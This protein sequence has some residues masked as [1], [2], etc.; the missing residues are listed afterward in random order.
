MAGLAA[1]VELA[2]NGEKVRILEQHHELGG[3][4]VTTEKDGFSL[5]LGPHAVYL[6]GVMHRTLNEWGVM[7]SGGRPVLAGDRVSMVI[8]GRRH[9]FVRDLTSLA[10]CTFMS[11]LERLEAGQLIVETE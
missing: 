8:G 10:A 4:A 11:P 5:N 3:R 2:R 1:A 6:D 9:P 7:P